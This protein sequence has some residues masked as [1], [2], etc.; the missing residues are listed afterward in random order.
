EQA[1]AE[2]ARPAADLYS[3]GA[4]LY[5]ALSGQVPFTGSVP[6]VL[7]A[8]A[9]Q[10][11]TRPSVLRA[12]LQPLDDLLLGLLA[13]SPADRPAGAA[14]LATALRGAAAELVGDLA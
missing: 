6:E 10:I 11:P 9:K 8:H 12:E 13:K 7:S 14:D 3:F 2:P 1:R 5:Q 4:L